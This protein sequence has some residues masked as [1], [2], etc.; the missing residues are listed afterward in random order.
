MVGAIHPLGSERGRR[1][2]VVPVMPV[3]DAVHFPHLISTLHVVR[4]AS[5][6]AIRRAGDP[7]QRLLVLSQRDMSIEEPRA[8]DLFRVGALSEVLQA[9]PMPDGS[10]RVALRGIARVAAVKVTS[11]AGGFWAEIR[12]IPEIEAQGLE[13]EAMVRAA[14]ESFGRVVGLN[15]S[16]PP[17]AIQSVLQLDSAGRVADAIL[18]HLPLRFSQK[19]EMLECA[20]AEIRLTRALEL[21]SREEQLLA[22][23][24]D[25]RHRVESEL[26]DAQ[27]EY[28]LREQLRIIQEELGVRE[29]G[30][31]EAENYRSRVA[32]LEAPPEA[33]QKATVELNRL[34]RLSPSSPEGAVLRDWLD[35][36]LAL[37][38]DSRT[39]ERLDV[40]AAAKVLD[41]RHFGIAKVKERVLDHL[42]VMQ[43]KRDLRGPILC[44]VGPPG[45]GKTSVGRAIAE[46]M[47][48]EFV[49]VSLGGVRDEAEIRGHRRT[50]VGAGPGRIL[51][52]LRQCGSRNPVFMLDEIDKLGADFRGDPTSALL[53]VLDPEQNRRFSD[54]Y[55][56]APFDLS[57]VFFIATANLLANVPSP[58][59]DR[60][61]VIHFGSYA[62]RE[63]L[64]IARQFLLPG[65][66]EEHGLGA[67]RL[68]IDEAALVAISGG[69][70]REAGVR[71][72]RRALA[73]IMRKCARRVAE[74]HRGAIRIGER[75]VP[76]LLG[77]AIESIR[78]AEGEV[79]S[80]LGLVVSERGGDTIMVE[81]SV[82]AAA[83]ERPRLTHT[84]SLG[85]VMQESAEAALT[86]IRARQKEL[87]AANVRFD[88]H[89]HV[90][91]AATPKDGPSAGLTIAIA[92]AS[93]LT[94]KSVLPRLAMS[95]EITLSGRILPV[96][97]IRDKVLA[98][99][100]AGIRELILPTG[101]E[102]E[103]AEVPEEVRADLDVHWL[104]RLS[105][106]LAIALP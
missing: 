24:A 35:V 28:F 59:R 97:G 49:R 95:G 81:A 71:D 80:A 37:P 90:P 39:E 99:H 9:L 6:R 47:G 102:G 10:V 16:I 7:D 72:L 93:A 4:E 36:F 55:L 82:M 23:N 29:K 101:N 106:A 86:C 5:L 48:R 100:A 70:T 40:R 12:E 78:W 57:G 20:D 51:Q 65:L 69:Y 76:K 92:L 42:A 68:V 8:S 15:K 88:A 33:I 75:D 17:E 63:R 44:F 66:L 60:M 61:E 21:V 50:Y 3:R 73:R 84:G 103:F 45:V 43:L 38:W 89:V 13:I 34:D 74:G 54:H 91:D 58:L 2:S 14:I 41:S 1:G 62:P 30:L 31:D 77:K 105:D 32:K 83:G 104:S 85:P 53:E 19:Q 67:D 11:R 56:E 25:I 46:A 22:L 52:G 64:E 27:R 96:G 87:S 98:A 94:G 18:H 26:G 79:G